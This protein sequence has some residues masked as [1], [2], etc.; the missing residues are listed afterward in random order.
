MGRDEKNYFIRFVKIFTRLSRLE[1][2]LELVGR[3]GLFNLIFG[4]KDAE[5]G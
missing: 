4:W 1:I 3:K 5:M 2:F